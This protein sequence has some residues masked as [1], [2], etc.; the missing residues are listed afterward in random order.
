MAALTL[1]ALASWTPGLPPNTVGFLR[2]VEA[3]SSPRLAPL[4]LHVTCDRM[5]PHIL[6][7]TDQPHCWR[8]TAPEHE[9]VEPCWLPGSPQACVQGHQALESRVLMGMRKYMNE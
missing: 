4:C 2:E 5:S 8:E 1:P 3:P 6:T 7:K 9:A